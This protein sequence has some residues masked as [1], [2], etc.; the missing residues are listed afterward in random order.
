MLMPVSL[1]S[2]VVYRPHLDIDMELRWSPRA[3]ECYET[4]H[5]RVRKEH[6][7]CLRA[8][9]PPEWRVMLIPSVMMPYHC[10]PD[11]NCESARACDRLGAAF[12]CRNGLIIFHRRPLTEA[13][14]TLHHWLHHYRWPVA[15]HDPRP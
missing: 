11:H 9:F 10:G 13:E 1:F 5:A 6:T 3:D 12:C 15:E 14:S 8:V 4:F 7:C 2:Q